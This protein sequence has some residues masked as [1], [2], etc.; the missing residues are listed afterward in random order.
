MKHSEFI[1]VLAKDLD[2]SQIEA[3]R[4]LEAFLRSFYYGLIRDGRLDIRELGILRVLDTP[5]RE[6]RSGITGK[7]HLVPASKRTSFH[8]APALRRALREGAEE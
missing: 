7:V 3:R 1:R 6:M 8:M 5:A 2:S 4:V